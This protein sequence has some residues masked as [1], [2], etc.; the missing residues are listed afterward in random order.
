MVALRKN[1]AATIATGLALLYMVLPVDFIP[2]VLL[3]IGWID[4]GIVAV[5]AF[6]YARKALSHMIWGDQP[7][8]GRFG[9]LL[10]WMAI[11]L[12]ISWLVQFSLSTSMS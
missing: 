12:L 6:S 2:D 10:G 4:D 3:V 5:S 11:F 9:K 1:I 7:V 8:K